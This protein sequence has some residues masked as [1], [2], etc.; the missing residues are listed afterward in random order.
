M[1]T[2][3]VIGLG[4]VG[5][6]IALALG[7]KY[8]TIGFDIS[9]DR[10]KELKS[11]VDSTGEIK[12][13]GGSKVEFTNNLEDLKEAT[14]YL[15]AVPTPVTSSNEPF[16]K[17]V[18][19]ASISVA[20]VISKN[21]VV[22]FESTVYPGVTEGLC[23]GVIEEISELKSGKD[24]FLGYSPERINPG[25]EKHTL[26]NTS[27]IVSGQD[28]ET[29]ERIAKV[30]QSVLEA[31]VHKAA[32]IQVAEMAKAVENAQRDIN[33]A[34]MNE[35]AMMCESFKIRTLDVL[36]ACKTKWNFLNFTPGI[37]GGHCISVDPYY[38]IAK[39]KDVGYPA[40]LLKTA[41][42]VNEEIP[43]FIAGKIQHYCKEK[44]LEDPKVGILGFSFKENVPDSRN[45]G[46]GRLM[47]ELS[48]LNIECV[49][50]CPRSDPALV[51]DEYGV[52]LCPF[53]DLTDLDVLVY[54]VP[55][56]EFEKLSRLELLKELK[57]GGF[58]V[59]LRGKIG[60][61]YSLDRGFQYWSL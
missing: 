18:V 56:D 14:F 11:Q 45:S 39:A 10:I 35:V 40:S 26:Y 46:P 19:D 22:V 58:L 16:L 1:E 17:Y 25:D 15:I 59:D 43:S 4:Y 7:K 33:I 20:K 50:H 44:G 27:K 13:F 34:F 47:K 31:P 36:E 57:A 2:V 6:P 55:H 38:L 37:V 29:L 48:Y 9:S 5:L 12:S 60:Y 23:G 8:K 21:N 49:A 53:E 54:A 24:F 42:D 28:K 32:S 52:F 30:Y 51:Y 41:R 3:G 61:K